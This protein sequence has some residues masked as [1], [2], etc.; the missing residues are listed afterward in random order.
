M[1]KIHRGHAPLNHFSKEESRCLPQS[2]SFGNQQMKNKNVFPLF[3]A[4]VV[5]VVALASCTTSETVRTNGYQRVQV[6]DVI[7]E[8]KYLSPN[9]EIPLSAVIQPEDLVTSPVIDITTL[10]ELELLTDNVVGSSTL[11]QAERKNEIEAAFEAGNV[12][13]DS[14]LHEDAYGKTSGTLATDATEKAFSYITSATAYTES[15]AEYDYIE[16]RIYEI[17]TSPTGITDLRL[18]PGEQIAGNPVTNDNMNWQFSLGTS[19]EDGV[20]VQHLFIRPLKVGLDTSMILLTNERTYYFR[21]ASFE[22]SYMTAV[23]F[24]YPLSISTGYIDPEVLAQY[25]QKEDD[26][27]VTDYR[28]DI[29]FAD[30]GYEIKTKGKPS[31]DPVTVFSDNVKTYIQFPVTITHSDQLP[32][33]YL[34]RGKEETLV[35]YRIMGNLY[36]ID[37]VLTG[38]QYFLLKSGQ[39]QTVEIRRTDR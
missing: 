26:P 38:D 30:Y 4:A 29:E 5:A 11:A 19:I 17:I 6:V 35:N 3:A 20:S 2:G 28:F 8:Q 27:S 14:E 23:R 32:S 25:M 37:A 31:W 36:Q 34:V 1:Q 10:K 9:D 33:V 21:L 22:K 39:K 7:D 16:G 15:I 24:R 13:V 18:K 12:T